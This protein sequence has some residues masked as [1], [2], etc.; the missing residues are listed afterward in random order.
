MVK[1]TAERPVSLDST[2][3]YLVYIILRKEQ[4]HFMRTIGLI[5]DCSEQRKKLNSSL[6]TNE[7]VVVP[8]NSKNEVEQAD[9]IVINLVDNYLIETIN[10]LL[11][12]KMNPHLF[13]LVIVPTLI[14]QETDV[15]LEL[16]ANNVISS[17]EMNNKIFYII[18][19]AFRCIE[20]RSKSN[21]KEN[22]SANLLNEINQSCIINGQ[23]ILLT[24][25][26]FIL[27]FLLN[28]R[29]NETVSYEDISNK[30]WP[31]KEFN[32]E[33]RRNVNIASVIFFIRKKLID[34]EYVIHTTRGKGYVLKKCK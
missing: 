3:N 18:E 15:F 12:L 11:S 28:S 14:E 4:L 13:V 6:N 1:Q 23:E 2:G 5:V 22:S 29:F 7:N 9:G 32:D 25:T 34:S 8:I 27:M 16:G 21:V 26:E 20:F 17:L 24:K 10:W 31:N 19:N 33:H 30:L